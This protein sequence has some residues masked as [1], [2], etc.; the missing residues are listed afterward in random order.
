MAQQVSDDDAVRCDAKS[1][2]RAPVTIGADV[3]TTTAWHGCSMNHKGNCRDS[4]PGRALFQQSQARM[5]NG[6]KYLPDKKDCCS[7]CESVHRILQLTPPAYR[8][9]QLNAHRI[10]AMCLA[11]YP[12]RLGLTTTPLQR[13][14]AQMNCICVRGQGMKQ[15]LQSNTQPALRRVLWFVV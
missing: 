14:S 11:G 6:K 8:E 15:S 9:G 4:A 12:V 7:G 3:A 5:V 13:W 10:C 1:P 2:I